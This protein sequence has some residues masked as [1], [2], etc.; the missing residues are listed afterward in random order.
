[1]G[2]SVSGLASGLDV[3]GIINQLLAIESSQLVTLNRKIA[4]LEAKK[5]AYTD[6][7]GRLNALSNAARRLND[8][9]IFGELTANTSD[10]SIVT[11]AADEGAPQ[12]TYA[13]RV[14]QLATT[15]RMASQ[16]LV[17]D[18]ATPIAAG[19]GALTFTVGDG[20][21]VGSDVTNSTTLRQLADAI[22]D[23]DADVRADIVN[24]GTLSN[25]Y[26]LV[27]TSELEGDDGL[28]A[29][30]NN[31]T[32]LDF[33][34]KV[35]EQATADPGNA[36]D[37]TGLVTSSGTYT[38]SDNNTFV[39]EII[40][41]GPADGT[42]RFRFSTDGGLNFDDNGG[43]GYAATAGAPIALADGVEVNF[44]DDGSDLKVG[45]EFYIDVFTPE[46]QAPQDAIIDINGINIRKSSNT[47]DDVF[48]G[49]TFTLNS[50]DVNKTVSLTIEQ[51][52][53][54]LT[55]TMGA[56]VGAYNA[57]VGFL[58]AQFSYDPKSGQLAP[59]LNGDSAARQI[60]R[61]VK[62][63]L[64]SRVGNL[65]GDVLSSLTEFGITS[66]E[67][68][69]LVSLDVSK[70]D[71]VLSDDPAQVQRILTQFGEALGDANFT[72]TS[73][74]S[75]SDEGNYAVEI[76]QART[77][78]EVTAGIAAEALTADEDITL[79]FDVDAQN[80][81][82]VPVQVVANL[83]NGDSVAQQTSRLQAAVDAA[84]LAVIVFVDADGAINFRSNEYG[85][86]FEVTAVSDRA[87]GVG[88]GT[89]G[90]GNVVLT[91]EGTN[92]EGT[93]GGLPTLTVDGHS[94]R[95]K[96]G[97]SAEGIQ[98]RIPDDTSGS[99]G[100]VRI[101]DGLGQSLPEVIK[102]LGLGSSGILASRSDGVD[103]S[104]EDLENQIN[105]ASRRTAQVE[106]RLR[107]QFTNLEVQL[108]QLN[109]LGDYVTQQMA[110]LSAS[111]NR[112]K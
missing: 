79:T 102:G 16:G 40:T 34:N 20:N 89:T 45:D 6:L 110:A 36:A 38:G 80:P 112:K 78:A 90:I 17:D 5:A 82:S 94:L 51:S 101:V 61:T 32:T 77:R 55:Q 106:V 70:L 104:I 64:T 7:D 25:P 97:F 12:G 105:R 14:L 43:A 87:A 8:D 18:S 19:A 23:T 81:A 41:E 48:E 111:N 50:A 46:L 84:D 39:V 60:Q 31:D 73:R 95:G 54:D 10:S 30:T 57:L 67:E 22:N 66:N 28:I 75:S 42:A 85:E 76:T 2:I 98:I 3:D 11:V 88:L 9:G 26:R 35:I 56:F 37:Y 24:D 13:L 62:D 71:A 100:Q 44:T 93:I 108:A 69:G 59:S 49:L 1:M 27:L 33:T 103:N 74:T 109:A 107:K 4:I 96:S 52:A 58:N 68:N 63:I 15:H 83:L 53:A 86:N 99:L 29:I 72:F 65:G 92:L 91:G 47:V 21:A